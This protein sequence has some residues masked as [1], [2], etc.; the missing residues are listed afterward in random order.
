V[1]HLARHRIDRQF[2]DH[3]VARLIRALHLQQEHRADAVLALLDQLRDRLP[4][5]RDRHRLTMP[6]V[7]NS[8]HAAFPA[9]LL[10][11]FLAGRLP[12]FHFQRHLSHDADSFVRSA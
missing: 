2:L 6:A 4:V 3:R 1:R 9:K 5:D 7:D 8:R 10:R 11:H 12:A